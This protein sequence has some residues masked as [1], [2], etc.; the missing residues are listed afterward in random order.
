MELMVSRMKRMD[1]PDNTA[2]DQTRLDIQQEKLNLENHLFKLDR[3][4]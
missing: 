2:K 3:D 4:E 1:S